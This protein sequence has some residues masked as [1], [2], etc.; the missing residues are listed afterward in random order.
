MYDLLKVKENLL[1][2]TERKEQIDLM[3]DTIQQ[4]LTAYEKH[5]NPKENEAKKVIRLKE[6]W[7]QLEKMSINVDKDIT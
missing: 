4:T 3:V 1:K 2:I 6:E 7:N 5:E